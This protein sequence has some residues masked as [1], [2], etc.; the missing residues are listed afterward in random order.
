MDKALSAKKTALE[1]WT[2]QPSEIDFQSK[3]VLGEGSFGTVYRGFCRGKEVAVKRLQRQI[4]PQNLKEL[5]EEVDTMSQ[6]LHPNVLLFMGVSLEMGNLMIV[7][8]YMPN[9]SLG[10]RLNIRER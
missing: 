2:I 8:E 4:K 9:G 5:I 6:L 3:K 7:T 1:K 10:F